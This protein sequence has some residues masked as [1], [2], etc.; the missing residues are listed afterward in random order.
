[1]MNKDDTASALVGTPNNPVY[2][3]I[4]ENGNVIYWQYKNH[5]FHFKA[6]AGSELEVQQLT[7]QDVVIRPIPTMY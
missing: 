5:V 6:A 2:Q 1:M 4:D 7:R 3:L